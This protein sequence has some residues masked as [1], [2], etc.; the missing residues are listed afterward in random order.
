[1]RIVPAD[2]NFLDATGFPFVLPLHSR[3]FLDAEG[4]QRSNPTAPH[5]RLN[6]SSSKAA[7]HTGA[8]ATTQ[9]TT[10]LTSHPLRCLKKPRFSL[11]SNPTLQPP[12]QRS[13]CPRRQQ[14]SSTVSVW[15][16]RAATRRRQSLRSTTVARALRTRRRPAAN[17]ERCGRVCSVRDVFYLFIESRD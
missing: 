12:Q 13:A 2:S 6:A 5:I 14:R 10:A 3:L 1:M 11:P 16:M 15:T 17:G 9:R 7:A 8:A 4:A